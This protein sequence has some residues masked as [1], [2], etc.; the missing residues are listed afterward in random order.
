MSLCENASMSS[1]PSAKRSKRSSRRR[2]PAGVVA[3]LRRRWGFVPAYPQSRYSRETWGAY[4]L[5]AAPAG[6]D[7]NSAEIKF[8][9][10]YLPIITVGWTNNDEDPYAGSTI[11]FSLVA[12]TNTEGIGQF[13]FGALD[14]MP[15][16]ASP[17]TN[18]TNQLCL[19]QLAPGTGVSNRVGAQI[20]VDRVELSLTGYAPRQTSGTNTGG[21]DTVVWAALVWAAQG[22]TT[23]IPWVNT[24]GGPNFP[25]WFNNQGYTGVSLSISPTGQIRN[26]VTTDQY[27]VLWEERWVT[28][29]GDSAPFNLE[30]TR[31][32]AIPRDL[33]VTRY[34]TTSYNPTT[35]G[36][37][38][39]TGSMP[40]T[41]GWDP[42]VSWGGTIRMCFYDA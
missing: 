35:G 34:D 25:V 17:G 8:A 23:A 18:F 24:T 3:P 33:G 14:P 4:A 40:S 41:T 7:L 27:R 19:N 39:I 42:Q 37:Y 29:L 28:G 6:F 31:S 26:P 15:G 30:C 1:K 5:P 12:P 16:F 9:D 20:N 22:I 21:S 2:K 13:G 36:L 11:P 10:I 38:L 32:I